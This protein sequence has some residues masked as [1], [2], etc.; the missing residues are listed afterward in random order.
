[1][2][3]IQWSSVARLAPEKKTFSLSVFNFRYLCFMLT[4][5]ESFEIRWCC[6]CQTTHFT[7]TYMFL[8]KHYKSQ[9]IFHVSV[10]F[11]GTGISSCLLNPPHFR[12]HLNYYLTIIMRHNVFHL[13]PSTTSRWI[14]M[15]FQYNKTLSNEKHLYFQ[16]NNEQ[17]IKISTNVFIWNSVHILSSRKSSILKDKKSLKWSNDPRKGIRIAKVPTEMKQSI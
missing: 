4:V 14:P 1:M 5:C 11:I 9:L 12:P 17:A 6:H 8:K 7:N 16:P 15:W 13:L 2:P 10:S 3:M